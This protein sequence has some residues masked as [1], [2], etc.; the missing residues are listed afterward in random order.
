[1]SQPMPTEKVK[2]GDAKKEFRTLAEVFLLKAYKIV[3]S[4]SQ[5]ES[6]V[7]IITVM[8][9]VKNLLS[10]LRVEIDSSWQERAKGVAYSVEE[11]NTA[12][13]QLWAAGHRLQSAMRDSWPVKDEMSLL[14]DELMAVQF[15]ESENN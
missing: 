12:A 9:A 2:Y 10:T 1:M 14:L 3:K 4:G 7:Q 11:F 8:Q 13:K 15:D 6:K 5:L